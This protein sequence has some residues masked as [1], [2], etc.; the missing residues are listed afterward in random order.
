[1]NKKLNAFTMVELLVAMAII[2][3]LIGLSIYGVGLAQRAGRDS[4]RR[5]ALDDINKAIAAYYNDNGRNPSCYRFQTNRLE[6]F[7]SN[8]C[9]V[10]AGPPAD[11]RITYNFNGAGFHN[12]NV[13]INTLNAVTTIGSVTNTTQTKYFFEIRTDGYKLAACMES[14][15]LEDKGTSALAWSTTPT[16]P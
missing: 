6:L 8:S 10:T 14:G 2:G 15:K 13:N 7:N 16:C 12:A 4:Q 9:T 11:P 5:G 3:I 1:M